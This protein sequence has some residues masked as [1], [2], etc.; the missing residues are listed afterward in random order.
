M[1]STTTIVL[2]VGSVLVVLGLGLGLGLGLSGKDETTTTESPTTIQPVTTQPLTQSTSTQKIETTT[3]T[4]ETTTARP[5]LSQNY[6]LRGFV[7]QTYKPKLVNPN[8]VPS[9]LGASYSENLYFKDE[10]D[11]NIYQFPEDQKILSLVK[12][13]LF[14]FGKT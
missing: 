11:I 12:R 1:V 3:S 13:W 9:G 2:G 5:I 4:S 10:G 6:T 7:E 14:I 8:W